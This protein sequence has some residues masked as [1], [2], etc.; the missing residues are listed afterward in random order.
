MK[1]FVKG[2]KEDL[3][4]LRGMTWAERFGLLQGAAGIGCTVA[5]IVCVFGREWSAATIFSLLSIILYR[6]S[7]DLLDD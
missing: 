5:S 2:L 4:T 3:V 7:S 1:D 6:N